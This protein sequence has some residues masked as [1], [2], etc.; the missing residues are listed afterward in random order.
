MVAGAPASATVA[1][2]H[3]VPPDGSGETGL[4][5]DTD[6]GLGPWDPLSAEALAGLF[7]GLDGTWWLTGGVALDRFVGR[8]TRR[9]DDIDVEIPRSDLAAILAHLN[10]WDAHTAQDG[11]LTPLATADGQPAEANGVWWRQGLGGAWRFDLRLA[12]VTGGDW[13]YRRHPAIRRALETVW[14]T[15]GGGIPVIAPEVQL[16]FKA[17]AERAKDTTDAEMVVPLLDARAR[18]WLLD[19]VRRAHPTSPWLAW[20]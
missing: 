15:D 11:V 20:L 7:D 4:V 2:G 19:A 14:W 16:L 10:G 1:S 17:R 18:Q 8:S 6:T 13:V 5:T 12:C 9:H 3:Q